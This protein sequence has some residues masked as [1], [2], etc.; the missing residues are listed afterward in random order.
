MDYSSLLPFHCLVAVCTLETHSWGSPSIFLRSMTLVLFLVCSPILLQP[1]ATS[2]P[3]ITT[4]CLVYLLQTSWRKRTYLAFPFLRHF[5][6]P[7]KIRL[8]RWKHGYWQMLFCF[9]WSNCVKMFGFFSLSDEGCVGQNVAL[10]KA[11]IFSFITNRES[12][13]NQGSGVTN[14]KQ[15]TEIRGV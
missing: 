13:Y 8:T 10:I 3:D 12:L 7:V 9:T 4:P 5:K 1:R 14:Q 2:A 6:S 11:F 15:D